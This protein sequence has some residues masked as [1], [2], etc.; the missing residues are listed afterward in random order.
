[1][2]RYGIIL[3]Q[4]SLGHRKFHMDEPDLSPTAANHLL[5][6]LKPTRKFRRLRLL[7]HR[8]MMSLLVWR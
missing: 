5:Q 8:T 2:A 6:R 1:M 7:V 3:Q 4:A